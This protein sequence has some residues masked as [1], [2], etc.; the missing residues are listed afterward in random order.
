MTTIR[1][2]TAALPDA[3]AI[4]ALHVASWKETYAGILPAAMLAELSVGARADMWRSVLDPSKGIERAA[5]VAEVDG[6][7]VGFGSC[8]PQRDSR[9]AGAGFSAEFGAIYL[10]RS[11]QGR[12][13]GRSLLAAMS[14]NLSSAGHS[15]A[16]LWVLR[17][18]EPA[19]AFYE[20]LGGIVVGER[21]ETGAHGALV[22]T[23]YGW[24][25]LRALA[26]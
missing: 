9:L 4:G 18:N 12:G 5:V 10:L 20:R 24:R 8:G 25:D 2:R 1:V 22:E 16:S 14:G 3:E 7:L 23:A 26:R 17:E 15:A 11:H 21:T 19:R 13:G 6:Q